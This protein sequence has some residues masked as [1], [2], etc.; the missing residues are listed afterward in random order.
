MSIEL[1]NELFGELFGELLGDSSKDLS[2]EI[3]EPPLVSSFSDISA[4]SEWILS[5]ILPL[6]SILKRRYLGTIILFPEVFLNLAFDGSSFAWVSRSFLKKSSGVYT[7]D[8][9]LP[10][11]LFSKSLNRFILV[12][13]IVFPVQFVR[14]SLKTVLSKTLFPV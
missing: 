12:K 9:C 13:L 3:L 2:V 10:C 7:K 8:V 6:L 1:F 5:S 11:F 4:S 14:N